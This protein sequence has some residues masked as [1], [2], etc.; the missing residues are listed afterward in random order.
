MN[1]SKRSE[2]KKTI[3]WNVS[4]R[5]Y[6]ELFSRLLVKNIL[7]YVLLNYSKFIVYICI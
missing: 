3:F 4:E 6:K 7:L 2:D 5:K 1:L